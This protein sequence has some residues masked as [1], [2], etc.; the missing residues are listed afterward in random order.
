MILFGASMVFLLPPRPS[1]LGVIFVTLFVTL[2]S[3]S[4]LLFAFG[5]LMFKKVKAKSKSLAQSAQTK[6]LPKIPPPKLINI[7]ASYGTAAQSHPSAT[8]RASA[9]KPKLSHKAIMLNSRT[10]NPPGRTLH[11]AVCTMK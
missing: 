6:N 4:H 7:T 2:P 11:L 8:L 10:A 5:L 9:Q 1:L 3:A